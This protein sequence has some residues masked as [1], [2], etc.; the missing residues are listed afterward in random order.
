MIEMETNGEKGVERREEEEEERGGG[1]RRKKQAD[2]D[3]KTHKQAKH[4]YLLKQEHEISQKTKY[5]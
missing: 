5:A 3:R 2:L 1:E 4:S